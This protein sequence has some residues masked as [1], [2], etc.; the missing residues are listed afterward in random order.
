MDNSNK[1]TSP[2]DGT[3]PE[4]NSIDTTNPDALSSSSSAVQATPDEAAS[5]KK[6]KS[7]KLPGALHKYRHRFNIYLLLFLLVLV[8]AGA[9]LVITALASRDT[10]DPASITSQTLSSDT[11]NQ[12]SN[13]DA[14]VGDPKQVLNIQSNAVFAGKVLVRDSLD[15][16]GTI[17]VG[18]SLSLPGITVSG[19]SNFDSLNIS[20]A[21]NIGGDASLQ[22]QLIVKKNIAVSGGGT[23]GG[24]ITAPQISTSNLQLLGDLILTRHITAGGATPGRSIGGAVGSGGTASVSGSDT[25]GSVNVNTGSGPSAGCFVTVN[26][27]QRFSNTPHVLIT[28]VGSEAGAISYYV[29]RTSNGFSVCTANVPPSNSAFGFDYFVLN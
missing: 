21:L 23:F 20:K 7:I 22:G 8:V 1:D 28:P 5:A 3:T 16:A 26:F 27:A 18:G 25:A 6:S 13:T 9:I 10:K 11:L 4:S 15:V 29:N 17:K 19:E 24:A 2:A 12:L 14:T